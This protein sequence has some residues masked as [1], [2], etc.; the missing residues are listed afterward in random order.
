MVGRATHVRQ[1]ASP[2]LLARVR[3][4]STIRAAANARQATLGRMAAAETSSMTRL[5][6]YYLLS[7]LTFG[8]LGLLVAP[9]VALALLFAQG[10]YGDALPRLCGTLLLGLAILVAQVIRLR[11][12]ALHTTT[13]IVRSFFL[14]CFIAIYVTSHDRLFLVLL[15]IVGLGLVLTGTAKLLDRRRAHR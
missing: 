14:V 4:R 8:G 13:L 5:S 3:A 15:G 9:K 12:D 10:D 2:R 11:I 6:L 1:S 7:Y